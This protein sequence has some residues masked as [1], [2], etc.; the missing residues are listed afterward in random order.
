MILRVKRILRRTVWA[1]QQQLK[2]GKYEPSRFENLF[3][4]GGRSESIEFSVIGG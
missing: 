3:F 1:L 2:A 4:Y